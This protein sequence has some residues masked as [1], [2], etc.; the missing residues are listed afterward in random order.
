MGN[1]VLYVAAAITTAIPGMLHLM[2]GPNALGFN[3]NQGILFLVG[4]IARYSGSYL[5]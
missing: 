4:G 1:F 5:C 3:V 2:M